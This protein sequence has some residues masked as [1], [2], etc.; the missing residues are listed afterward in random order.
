MQGRHLSFLQ[1]GG[2][3]FT[4]FLRELYN[5]KYEKNMKKT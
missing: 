1:G 4:D 3:M 5:K 2:N